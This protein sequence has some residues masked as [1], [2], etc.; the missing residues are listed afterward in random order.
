M[1]RTFPYKLDEFPWFIINNS[2]WLSPLFIW[3][4]PQQTNFPKTFRPEKGKVCGF[5]LGE[6]S[7]HSKSNSSCGQPKKQVL[8]SVAVSHTQLAS[9]STGNWGYCKWWIFI[10]ILQS[11]LRKNEFELF[12][13]S[14]AAAEKSSKTVKKIFFIQN[15]WMRFGGGFRSSV[16]VDLV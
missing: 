1:S 13:F 6:T 7:I 2:G 9:L 11:Q 15:V 4:I 8:Y 3:R 10:Q 5:F 16:E 14:V 12:S